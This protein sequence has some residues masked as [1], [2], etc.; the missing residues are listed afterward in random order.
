MAK[1]DGKYASAELASEL[2]GEEPGEQVRRWAGL[3]DDKQTLSLLDRL[4]TSLDAPVEQTAIGREIIGREATETVD[5]AV[6]AGH[7][8]QMKAATGFTKQH[9]GARECLSEVAGRLSDEGTVGL[10]FGAPGSGKTSLCIDAATVWRAYT[11]GRVIANID[12]NGSDGTFK[13]D[14]EMLE[15]MASSKGQTL[16]IV[17]EVAQELSGFG[18]GNKKVEAFSDSLLFIRK[19]ETAHGPNPKR[20]SVLAV[21]HTRTKTAK[22]IRRVASFG[23]E[24]PDKS[25]KHMARLLNSEGGKDDWNELGSYQGL[26]DSAESFD[27]YQA[28]AF[29]VS[30]NYSDGDGGDGDSID[31]SRRADIQTVITLVETQDATYTAAGDAVG[32]S[33]SWVSDRVS[34]HRDGEFS[35]WIEVATDES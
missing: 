5:E 12:W 18:T 30:E 15:Q 14:T 9:E 11:G 7:V 26:T 21:G 24:K 1:S 31:V 3:I 34:E 28:S 22:S 27:E 6:R 19:R 4:E 33:S 23:V 13:S 29:S 32:Y 20:G 25:R 2:R 8:S 16:A 17:D 10:V 35:D